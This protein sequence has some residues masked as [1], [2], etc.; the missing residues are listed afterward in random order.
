M[1]NYLYTR[2]YAWHDH[3]INNVLQC[4][5]TFDKILSPPCHRPSPS[6]AVSGPELTPYQKTESGRLMR[7]NHSGEVCAQALYL[8]QMIGT[9][10]LN[11][12]QMLNQAAQEESDHL[13]WCSER[14]VELETHHSYLNPL[15]FSGALLI[16]TC[17]SLI[18]TRVSLGFLEETENQVTAHLESHLTKLP[19]EDTKSRAIIAQM[20]LD[21]AKHASTAQ[22]YGAEALPYMIKLGMRWS[23]KIMTHIA[24]YV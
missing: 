9:R 11:L 16:G 22:Q 3:L 24:Y 6:Q 5:R 2:H 13:H 1:T 18:S 15:W 14:L 20:R 7:V 23:A 12:K 17:A 21:E 19:I 10:D 4:I 8:G